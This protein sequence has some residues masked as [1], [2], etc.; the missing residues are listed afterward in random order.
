MPA[1]PNEHGLIFDVL[2]AANGLSLDV[3]FGGGAPYDPADPC[4]VDYGALTWL[5]GEE[6]IV[7][8]TPTAHAEQATLPPRSACGDVGYVRKMTIELA[9][10]FVG[11]VVRDLSGYVHLVRR[12]PN[13]V[14]VDLPS[15]WSLKSE[16]DRPGNVG[17]WWRAYG[18]SGSTHN[19]EI[20]QALG[21]PIGLEGTVR[22]S[23]ELSNGPATM[24]MTPETGEMILAWDF[25]GDG[26]AIIANV[27]DF[28][29]DQLLA[30]GNS[31]HR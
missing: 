30:L 13:L 31:A 1:I 12:P 21:G 25:E 5:I 7:S 24:W 16:Q 20:W 17:Y 10:A 15:A 2:L 4:S 26:V 28:S 14:E 19:L 11:I 29:V 27:A 9:Q 6:L 8:I 18:R 22:R 23:V 3:T